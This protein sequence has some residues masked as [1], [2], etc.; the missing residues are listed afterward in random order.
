MYGWFDRA[1]FW[2]TLAAAAALGLAIL[3]APLLAGDLASPAGQRIMH[4]LADEGAVRKAAACTAVGLW[5]C[6]MIFFRG[7]RAADL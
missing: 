1:C 4:L 3:C 5:F 6:A 7:P 2:L